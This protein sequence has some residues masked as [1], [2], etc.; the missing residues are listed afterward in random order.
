MKKKIVYLIIGI[1]CLSIILAVLNICVLGEI[2]VNM[3]PNPMET[4]ME[5]LLITKVLTKQKALIPMNIGLN[6]IFAIIYCF[7]LYK[8]NI[9]DRKEKITF[10]LISALLIIPIIISIKIYISYNVMIIY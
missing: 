7:V 5:S 10:F 8:K 3:M 9:L 1:I 2:T 4:Y 6:M